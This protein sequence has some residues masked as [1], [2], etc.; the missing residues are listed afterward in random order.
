MF[1]QGIQKLNDE[2]YIIQTETVQQ[3]VVGALDLYP[4]VTNHGML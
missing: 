1:R 3:N 2:K 4:M